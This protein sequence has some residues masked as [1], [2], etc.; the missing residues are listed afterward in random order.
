[1]TPR[2]WMRLRPGFTLVETIVTLGL[3]AVLAAFVVPTVVQKA[4]AGDPVK[5]VTD[6]SSIQTGMSTFQTDIG[7]IAGQIRM[8]TVQ[9]SVSNHFVDSVTSLKASEV[10][11]WNGPY[12]NA[13]IGFL[14]V[15]S[16]AT[17]FRAFIKNVIV[18]FDATNNAPEYAVAPGSG[19][20]GT[21]DVNNTIFATLTVV[22]LSS[23]QA[24]VI[25]RLIDGDDDAEVIAGPLTGA[26]TQG[27]FR[28]DVPNAN[29]IVVAYYLATPIAK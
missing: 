20:G 14:A 22:G 16:L 6:L 3:L 1:M 8:L 18:R 19:T 9:P 29:A 15:D 2:G 25:N 26:N 28:Y 27:R 24:R 23:T 10:Q 7:G 17:G 5:V 4:G 21:F 12:V 11:S 13:E